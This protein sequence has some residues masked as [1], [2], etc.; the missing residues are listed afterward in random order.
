MCEETLAHGI[1]ASFQIIPE[2]DHLICVFVWV[3]VVTLWLGV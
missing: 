2:V 1:A 3:Q